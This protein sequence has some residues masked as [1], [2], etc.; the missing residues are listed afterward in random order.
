MTLNCTNVSLESLQYNFIL[1]RQNEH[2]ANA[3]IPAFC[4]IAVM[5]VIGIPGNLCVILVYSLRLRR[6]TANTFMLWL[7]VFDLLSCCIG[8]PMALFVS[9]FPV[10]YGPWAP[11]KI[12]RFVELAANA[13]S[14][15]LFVF[16]ALDRYRKI[17]NPMKRYSTRTT[18]N[19]VVA[20][21]CIG[22]SYSWP[23]I[24]IMGSE[25]VE[26]TLPCIFGKACGTADNMVATVYPA[27]FFGLLYTTILLV[28]MVLTIMYA[29]IAVDIWRWK[30]TVVGGVQPE[31][32]VHTKGH[33]QTIRTDVP[34]LSSTPTL[35]TSETGPVEHRVDSPT[36]A[37][38]LT[39]TSKHPTSTVS[40]AQI[41]T[42]TPTKPCDL[43]TH[44]KKNP[45]LK[46]PKAQAQITRTVVIFY[47]LF[48]PYVCR[49][50]LFFT[51]QVLEKA[52][53][54]DRE[55]MSVINSMVL[56]VLD[57]SYYVSNVINPIIYSVLNPQFRNEYINMFLDRKTI[58]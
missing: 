55:G 47:A 15:W 3:Y 10:M 17:H 31:S 34:S 12:V 52:D 54:I 56:L 21:V 28:L 1:W 24:I 57:R 2:I 26:T 20:A 22:I 48:V 53:V 4:F 32:S 6:T 46:G 13:A 36:K 45:T 51:L 7:S 5:V 49:Y 29:K 42:E 19:Q 37:C 18:R 41:H 14:V 35:S 44:A 40:S 11:C 9:R 38:D 58:T 25:T 39:Q 23:A 43:I 8:M 30:H 50:V 27:I 33:I 16:I